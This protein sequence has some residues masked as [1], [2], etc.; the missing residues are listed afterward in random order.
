MLLYLI[1]GASYSKLEGFSFEESVSDLSEESIGAKKLRKSNIPKLLIDGSSKNIQNGLYI[2][3]T[4]HIGT[5]QR[6]PPLAFEYKT[7]Q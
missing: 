4:M 1:N 5:K 7:F 3:E 2:S 6:L